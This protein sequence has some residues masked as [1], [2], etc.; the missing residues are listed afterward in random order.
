MFNTAYDRKVMRQVLDEYRQNPTVNYD[1]ENSSGLVGGAQMRVKPS[2]WVKLDADKEYIQSGNTAEAPYFD[3]G[4]ERKMNKM[5]KP[6]EYFQGSGKKRGRPRKVVGGKVNK[7]KIAKSVV[8][9]ALDFAPVV[10]GV[11][12]LLAGPEG[13]IV[14]PIT[15]AVAQKT[16]DHLRKK[17]GWG[18]GRGGKVNKKKIAKSVV[19]TAL[20][21]APVLAGVAPLLAG[22][23][24]AI[25]S[26]VTGAVAQKARDHLKKKTGWGKGRGGKLTK[27]QKV[28]KVVKPIISTGLDVLP[29]AIGTA[30]ANAYPSPFGHK[31]GGP[32]AD[33]AFVGAITSNQIRKLR[34]KVRDKTGYGFPKRLVVQ[35]KHP[36]YLQ[37]IDHLVT[38]HPNLWS[39]GKLHPKTAQKI[40]RGIEPIARVIGSTALD[41]VLPEALEYV[42]KEFGLP[43]HTG[44]VIGSFLRQT[45]RAKTGFG[46]E[47]KPMPKPI[48]QGVKEYTGGAKRKV[49]DKM[50]RRNQ[51]VKKIMKEQGM[52][53]RNASKY[54]KEHK[55]S[56]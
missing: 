52:S 10:A 25:V 23:E 14:S 2:K 24:G 28:K 48:P 32:T 29:I 55:L 49:S 45:I 21:F 20:D 41:F 33:R 43:E 40:W 18:K 34:E 30:V 6:F 39:G 9:T 37:I 47:V 12:P 31:E 17:T 46:K 44:K 56:Y 7:G 38:H 22:P 27:S 15:G 35:Y 4:E 36:K 50:V 54:I 3:M 8:S 26:P 53:L 51:L 42:G 5:E 19:S 16:R 13:A 1:F 11:A